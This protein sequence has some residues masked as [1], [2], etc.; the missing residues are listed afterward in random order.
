MGKWWSI[1]FGVTMIACTLLFVVSPFVGW[2]LPEG[3]ST[4][5]WSV[6]LLFYFILGITG[7]FF[8]L[9]EALMCIFMYRY[10]SSEKAGRTVAHAPGFFVRTYNKWTPPAIKGSIAKV[11]ND[12]HKIEMA[13]TVLPAVILLWIAFAQVDAWAVIKYQ[14]R[15]PRYAEKNQEFTPLQIDVTARQWEWRIRYPSSERFVEWMTRKGDPEILKDFQSFA[16]IE[17][18]DDVKLVN[19]LHVWNHHPAVLQLS[20]RD[21]IHSFNLP[22]MRVKQDSLPGKQIPVWFTPIKHNTI[23]LSADGDVWIDGYNP[24]TKAQDRNQIWDLSCA[25]LCGWGHYRM[26]GRLYVHESQQDFLDW[27]KSVEAKMLPPR[28]K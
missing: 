3:V 19:E 13:W 11:L 21:V 24:D 25:E 22:H 23:R 18:K 26:V 20:T 15:M 6:D 10:C 1:L 4:H 12:P 17:Q 27:L 14:S 9:T 8:I 7:F 16:K 28:A 5:S 2:W